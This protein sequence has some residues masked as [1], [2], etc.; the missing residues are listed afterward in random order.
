MTL[1]GPQWYEIFRFLLPLIIF[2]VALCTGYAARKIV[3]MR[4]S[5]WARNTS[6]EVDDI[7]INA[8]RGPF[9]IWFMMLGISFS[10]RFAG[11]PEEFFNIVNKTL[12]VLGVFSIT[13]VLSNIAAGLI[14]SYSGKAGPAMPVTSFTQNISRII[15]FTIGL[16]IIL[17]NMGISIAPILATLGVGGLA[18]ALALQDTLSNFFSGFYIIVSRQV[19]VGDFVRLE[20]GDEGFVTDINWRTT[21]IRMLQ[22]NVLLIPNEKLT[23][24]VIINYYQPDREIAVTVKVGVHY[25]SDLGN[26]ER[27]TCEEAA[28]VMKEVSGGVPS[29]NPFV[30]FDGFGDYAVQMTVILRAVEFTDQYLVKHEFIKRL[31]KRYDRE[32]IVIPYPV[33]ALNI[34]QEKRAR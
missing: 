10:A 13:L 32:G 19:K 33:T 26:V 2:L 5:A 8:V 6:T 22:N 16:L 15:I 14:R 34:S 29:F 11:L 23:K 4:L 20:S 7:I 12:V 27:V 30:R 31:H 9:I 18:V 28:A 25:S 21:K 24:S 3:F 17:R 1:T